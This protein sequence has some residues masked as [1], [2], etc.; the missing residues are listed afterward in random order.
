MRTLIMETRSSLEMLVMNWEEVCYEIL[1]YE[2]NVYKSKLPLFHEFSFLKKHID[3]K[4]T[5]MQIWKS[6]FIF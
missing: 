6:P 4:D 2:S 1:D 5:L 3:V